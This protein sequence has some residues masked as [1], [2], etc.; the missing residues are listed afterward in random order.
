MAVNFRSLQAANRRKTFFLLATFGALTWLLLFAVFT[1]LGQS[2][3][4]IVPFAVVISLI[5]VWGSYF[6]SDKLEI[7]RAH[8]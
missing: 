5:M 3:A 8:V 4:A 2:S 6:S 1:Y 7:G